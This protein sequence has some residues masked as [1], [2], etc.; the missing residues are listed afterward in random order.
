MRT[1]ESLSKIHKGREGYRIFQL[2]K[3]RL[4]VVVILEDLDIEI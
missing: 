3:R 2:C 1:I 4:K